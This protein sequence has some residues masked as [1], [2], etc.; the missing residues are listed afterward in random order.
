MTRRIILNP[1]SIIDDREFESW[2]DGQLSSGRVT[3]GQAV[4]LTL[5]R[6][7]RKQQDQAADHG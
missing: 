6:D 7:R 4:E 1:V 2:L 3:L 5:Q